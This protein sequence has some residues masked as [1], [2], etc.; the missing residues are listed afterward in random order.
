MYSV[1]IITTYG[2]TFICNVYVNNFLK[3]LCVDFVNYGNS[4]III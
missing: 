4:A 2:W 1:N 3:G